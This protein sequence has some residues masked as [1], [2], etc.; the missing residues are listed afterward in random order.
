MRSIHDKL[1]QCSYIPLKQGRIH[2]YDVIYNIW[3]LF[4]DMELNQNECKAIASINLASVTILLDASFSEHGPSSLSLLHRVFP[5][6][7]PH[8]TSATWRK[9]CRALYS[10]TIYRPVTCERDLL[11]I[12]GTCFKSPCSFQVLVAG[13]RCVELDCWDGDDGYPIIYHGHTLTTKIT[14]KV[15][16]HIDGVFFVAY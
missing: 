15:L 4:I 6:Y 13:C 14:F 2:K 7:L 16:L 3:N 9:Q 8:R 1:I 12:R 11:K 5:Q 10:G